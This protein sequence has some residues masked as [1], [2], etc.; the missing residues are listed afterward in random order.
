MSFLAFMVALLSPYKA[1]FQNLKDH[2]VSNC[3]WESMGKIFAVGCIIENSVVLR[4][5]LVSQ[6]GV[7]PATYRLGGGCSIH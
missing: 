2:H 1:L 5:E 4:G 3:S 7:E 6:A